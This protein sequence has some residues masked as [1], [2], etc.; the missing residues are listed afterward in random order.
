MTEMTKI[1]VDL[2]NHFMVGGESLWGS[3]VE[4]EPEHYKVENVPYFVYGVALGDIVRAVSTADHPREIVSLVRPGGQLTLRVMF[5]DGVDHEQQVALL[6]PLCD[7]H[8][9]RVEKGYR[10]FWALSVEEA[11]C[12]PVLEILRAARDE[13]G[14]LQLESGEQRVEGSFD[15]DPDEDD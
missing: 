2:P 3:P 6:K 8:G 12:E 11:T 9:V 15:A 7:E 10:H 1:H 4:G 14:L 13:D 5:D